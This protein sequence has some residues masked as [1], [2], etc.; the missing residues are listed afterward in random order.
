MKIPRPPSPLRAI[1]SES[2]NEV[3][4]QIME[5]L[6]CGHVVAR[7]CDIYGETYAVR[8]RCRRCSAKSDQG[9]DPLETSPGSRTFI[10][11]SQ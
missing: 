8:R 5:T 9:S 2:C 7:R 10:T 4:G 11:S 3:T 1:V 6:E